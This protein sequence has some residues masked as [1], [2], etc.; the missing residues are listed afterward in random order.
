MRGIKRQ[1]T[2]PSALHVE[3]LCVCRGLSRSLGWV[4]DTVVLAIF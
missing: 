1:G 2:F 4:G 3:P